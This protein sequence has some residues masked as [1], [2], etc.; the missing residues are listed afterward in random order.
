MSPLVPRVE[1]SNSLRCSIS[2]AGIVHA[3]QMIRSYTLVH[4]RTVWYAR[5]SFGMSSYRSNSLSY[6][7]VCA[8][9]IDG[10]YVTVL[11]IILNYAF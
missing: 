2:C 10:N 8:L 4:A 7:L 11:P 1:K 3:Y 5:A 6:I 9:V